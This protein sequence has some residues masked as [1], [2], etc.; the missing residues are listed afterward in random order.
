MKRA[1]TWVCECSSTFT[2]FCTSYKRDFIMTLKA[3]TAIRKGKKKKKILIPCVTF[4]HLEEKKKKKS[5]FKTLHQDRLLIETISFLQHREIFIISESVS[6]SIG[7]QLSL[8][9]L[10]SFVPQDRRCQWWTFLPE[11]EEAA[12]WRAST[13]LGLRTF[14]L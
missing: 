6:L 13:T 12:S 7:Q 14:C 5:S 4:L 8:Q 9:C 11:T 3:Q 10:R 1:N 2:C